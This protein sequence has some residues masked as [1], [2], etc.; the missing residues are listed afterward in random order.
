MRYVLIILFYNFFEPILN[1]YV[2][3]PKALLDDFNK[4]IAP[5]EELDT[6][7]N[8]LSKVFKDHYAFY[9]ISKNP[10][11]YNKYQNKV[12]IEKEFE[13][14]QTEN[15]SAYRFYQDIARLI[16][17]LNDGHTSISNL[18][19][20]NSRMF[21]NSSNPAAVLIPLVLYIKV[22]N[23]TARIFGKPHKN[24]TLYRYFINN[25]T[26]LKVINE[27]LN[28]PIKT[29]NNSDPFDYIMNLGSQYSNLRNPHGSFTFFF[30]NLNRIPL[31][32]IPLSIESLTNFKVVYDNNKEFTT[33][34]IIAYKYK[35]NNI[36]EVKA[37]LN[38]NYIYNELKYIYA[39]EFEELPYELINFTEYGIKVNRPKHNYA[40]QDNSGK[41]KNS[42][43][44]WKYNFEN[45]FKCGIYNKTNIYFISSFISDDE[46]D[47]KEKDFLLRMV[48]C[49]EYFDK[50][51]YPIFLITNMNGGGYGSL[52]KILIEF[53]SPH[54]TSIF[55]NRIRKTKEYVDNDNTLYFTADKCKIKSSKDF[56]S[57]SFRA[58]YGENSYD[59][60][61]DIFIEEDGLIR[62]DIDDVKLNLKRPRK[63]TDIIVFTDGFSFSATGI[64]LKILQ[65]NGGAITVGFFGNPK[66]RKNVTFDS[67]QSPSTIVSTEELKKLSPEFNYLNKKYK[68]QMQFARV[69]SFYDRYS[70]KSYPL[71]YEITPVDELIPLYENFSENTNLDKFMEY[72][73]KILEK[74]K[75]E[76]N[77]NNKKLYLLNE[78]CHFADKHMHGGYI[79]GADGKWDYSKCVP[80][81]CD[82]YYIFD[83]INQTCV[84]NYC[85]IP[86]Y[87][88]LNIVE[89]SAL[90]L[91]ILIVFGTL[92]YLTISRKKDNDKI[93]NSLL[94]EKNEELLN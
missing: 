29:I 46:N 11:S 93:I 22:T 42:T 44:K 75:K 1:I 28:V 38:F 77:P 74:Y 71:E 2:Y 78:T 80:T 43:F 83:H 89:N 13:K 10:P 64:F 52:S 32:Y 84:F 61:T 88:A 14:M 56:V 76:C 53:L 31:S 37:G 70:N 72:G 17:K 69:Q 63:P 3:R 8:K 51:D 55:Y 81:Y 73:H 6:F 24:R 87:K 94:N 62:N 66:L 57:G 39:P 91:S 16:G 49:A 36:P 79:C 33:E 90:A 60:L 67:S 45:I 5:K 41:N 40:I 15:R 25:E 27:S 86:P 50:N 54:S 58:E 21:L 34:F 47:E 18:N 23:G 82:M 48:K 26:V 20:S 59:N 85:T 9:E 30:N 12:D 68:I 92:I 7:K 19:I 4:V 35:L 65:Y